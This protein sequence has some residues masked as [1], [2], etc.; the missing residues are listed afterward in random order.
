MLKEKS[1]KLCKECKK[2]LEEDVDIAQIAKAG[3]I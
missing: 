2:Q 3:K 1:G